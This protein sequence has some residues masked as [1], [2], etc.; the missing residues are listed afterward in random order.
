MIDSSDNLP[1]IG[2]SSKRDYQSSQIN[3]GMISEL[4]VNTRRE[5]GYDEYMW[6]RAEVLRN[7]YEELEPEEYTYEWILPEGETD[8]R[9][10]SKIPI[11]NLEI[12]SPFDLPELEDLMPERKEYVRKFRE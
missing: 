5:A 10:A 6:A 1:I 4:G 3:I 9:K 8:G 11:E 12:V 7:L 2:L